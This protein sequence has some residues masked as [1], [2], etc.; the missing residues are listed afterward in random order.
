MKASEYYKA[1]I[2]AI[3]EARNKGMSP[4]RQWAC[5]MDDEALAEL[6]ASYKEVANNDC[7]FTDKTYSF[8]A[9]FELR[10]HYMEFTTNR[11]AISY[12]KRIKKL[13]KT[14]QAICVQKFSETVCGKK[15]WDTVAF[16]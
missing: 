1:R 11:K 8:T 12:A 9:G 2:E 6:E 7:E 10:H 5:G 14:K 13:L 3:K 16:I 15:Y 4:A